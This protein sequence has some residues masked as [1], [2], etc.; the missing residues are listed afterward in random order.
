[1][2][3]Y[4][5]ILHCRHII[6]YCVQNI[7]YNTHII[8]YCVQNIVYNTAVYCRHIIPM[9]QNHRQYLTN[10]TILRTEY[11]LQYRC[12]LQT[13]HTILHT[14][15]CLQ[16]TYHTILCKNNCLQYSFISLSDFCITIPILV[17]GKYTILRTNIVYNT[18]VYYKHIILTIQLFTV[19]L[20][21][22]ITIYWLKQEFLIHRQTPDRHQTDDSLIFSDIDCIGNCRSQRLAAPLKVLG[23]GKYQLTVA[24]PLWRSMLCLAS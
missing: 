21:F 14:K 17:T 15:Y 18:N 1:M 7:V 10:H 5:A 16:Y 8:Q 3:L 11:C 6:Q 19:C 12:F 4:M 22:C 24:S 23:L 2:I 13:Y 9:I 20:D